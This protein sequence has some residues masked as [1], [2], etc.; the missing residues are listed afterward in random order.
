MR[1]M[2]TGASVDPELGIPAAGGL[3]QG[4][5]VLVE[6]GAERIV[7]RGTGLNR[8]AAPA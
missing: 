4:S 8:A 1:G 2:M 6:G 7:H 3:P 5:I